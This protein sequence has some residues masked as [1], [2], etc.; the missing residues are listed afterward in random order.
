MSNNLIAKGPLMHIFTLEQMNLV[1]AGTPFTSPM[2][3]ISPTCYARLFRMKVLHKAFLCM[4][5]RLNFIFVQEYWRNCANKMLVKLTLGHQN[6]C[7]F[8]IHKR[9]AA[10]L[11]MCV[12][13]LMLKATLDT[14]NVWPLLISGRCLRLLSKLVIVVVNSGL[15]VNYCLIIKSEFV[16]FFYQNRN[17]D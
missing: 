16:S 14:L 7:I 8:H 6:P 5:W 9:E 3:S 13:K 1:L 12:A 2:G 10:N 17:N 11:H 4:Q 15:I